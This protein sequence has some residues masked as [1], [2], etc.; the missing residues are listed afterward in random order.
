M[1]VLTKRQNQILAY[2]RKYF[3]D[4]DQLPP[5]RVISERFGI[6]PNAVNQHLLAL[7]MKGY[8]EPNQNGK[9]RFARK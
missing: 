2:L 7:E 3:N 9:Y 5:T 4:N 1:N 6:F 8:L